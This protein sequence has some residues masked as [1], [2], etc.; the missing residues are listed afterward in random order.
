MQTN[1]QAQSKTNSQS[2]TELKTGITSK[3]SLKTEV[4]TKAQLEAKAQVMATSQSRAKSTTNTSTTVKTQAKTEAK[5]QMANK[6][7]L[8]TNTK[9][10]TNSKA[11]VKAE[12][13]AKSQSKAVKTVNKLNSRRSSSVMSYLGSLYNEGGSFTLQEGVSP[14]GAPSPIVIPGSARSGTKSQAPVPGAGGAT[15]GPTP[16][17]SPAPVATPPAAEVTPSTTPSA[18][19]VP[20]TDETSIPASD[21]LQDWLMISSPSFK[22]TIK[23]P[24]VKLPSGQTITI[25]SDSNNFRINEAYKNTL[26]DPEKAPSDRYFWFR[27]VGSNIYYSLTEPDINI[28]GVVSIKSIHSIR[29]KNKGFLAFNPTCFEV[30][31][32]EN[33]Q[34]TLCANSEE[35]MKKWLCK[36]QIVLFQKTLDPICNQGNKDSKVTVIEK[37]ITQPIIIIPT[38]SPMCNEGWNYHQMG[39]DWNCECAEGREQSPINLPTKSN[40]I[41]TVI[42]PFFQYDEIPYLNKETTLDG[43]VKANKNLRIKLVDNVLRIINPNFGKLITMDG[44]VYHAQEISIHTPSEHTIDGKKYDME[45]QIVHF[46]QT[47]GDIAKQVVVSFLFEGRPG[48]YNKF[49]DD[50]DFFNLPNPINKEVDLT[51]NIYIPKIFY[52]AEDQEMP[53]WKPFSFYTYQGSITSPPCTERTIMYVASKPLP[54]STTALQLFREALRVPD[55]INGKGDVIVSDWIPNNSRQT[56]PLNGRPVFHYDH[57]KNCGPD[58]VK[59]KP[60][61]KGHY[62][63]VLK[64]ATN[65]FYVNDIHPSGLPGAFVVSDKEALGKDLKLI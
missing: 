21:I 17:D 4:K 20:P 52:S 12:V 60:Q 16:Q 61:P 46:G 47:K 23:F 43:M 32:L 65:Y 58:P 35:I 64:S 10:E 62:E 11:Q 1:T 9:I 42:R 39:R 31:D 57:E 13:I 38:P 55:V 6:S 28:L 44:A 36:L 27:Q 22:N 34:W 45:I 48:V 15:T 63:K 33:Q 7:K 50:L 5:S 40:A 2:K 29:K 53:T 30:N 37:I 56:Q 26:E 49:I 24:P 3:T 14:P 41:D 25:K 8:G 51:H 54:I 18:S 19:G 59:H